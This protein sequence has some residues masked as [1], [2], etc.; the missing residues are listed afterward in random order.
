M[1]ELDEITTVGS[2][3]ARAECVLCTSNGRTYVSDCRGGVT[4][5]E[6][7]GSQWSL[8]ARQPDFKVQPNGITLMQDGS[9]LLCHLGADSGGVFR[10][11]DKGDLHPL[12]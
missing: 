10:L 4:I 7:D 5:L 3:L 2:N 9:I 12:H 11:G 8:L 1:I 6:P